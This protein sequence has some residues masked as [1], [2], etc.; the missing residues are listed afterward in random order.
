MKKKSICTLLII[1]FIMLSTTCTFAG[2]KKASDKTKYLVGVPDIGWLAIEVNVSLIENYY[3]ASSTTRVFND[4]CF[5]VSIYSPN[6]PVALGGL[7]K[8]TMPV[9]HYKA[10]GTLI[11]SASWLSKNKHSIVLPGTNLCWYTHKDSTTSIS[12]PRNTASYA[13]TG[14][15]ITGGIN[16]VY[17]TI[18]INKMGS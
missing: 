15:L 3:D 11:K 17:K 8:S 13:T 10:N 9:S 18:R 2:T 7:S 12:H 6:D 1:I 4:R 5:I 16:L 14:Y